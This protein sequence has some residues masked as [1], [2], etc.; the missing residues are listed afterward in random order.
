M[1]YNISHEVIVVLDLLE[2]LQNNQLGEIV[3]TTLVSMVPVVRCV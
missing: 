2:W 3:F 1:W